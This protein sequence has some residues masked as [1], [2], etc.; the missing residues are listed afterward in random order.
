MIQR[1]N[2]QKIRKVLENQGEKH[3]ETDLTVDKPVSLALITHSKT[4]TNT[5]RATEGKVSV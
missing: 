5:K 1:E 3:R 4:H 2:T